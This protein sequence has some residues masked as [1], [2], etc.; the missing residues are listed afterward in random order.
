MY[1]TIQKWGNSRAIRLPKAVLETALMK[2]NEP[3]RIFAEPD[4]IVIQKIVG[5]KHKT[6]KERLQGFDGAYA[7]EEWDTGKPVGSEVF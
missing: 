4:K 2:E 1:S 7:F 6:L 3:V 5:T